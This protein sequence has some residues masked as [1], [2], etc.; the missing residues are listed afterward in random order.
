MV[1]RAR[2]QVKTLCGGVAGDL[3][4]TGSGTEAVLLGMV[5]LARAVSPRGGHLVI[6]AVEHRAGLDAGHQLESLGF[7][8]TWVR[9]DPAGHLDPARVAEALLPDTVLVSIMHAN[10]ETGVIHPVAEIAGIC[11]GRGV[12]MHVD[13]IQSAGKIPVEADSWGVDGLSLAA[14]KLGGPQGV[15]ALWRRRGSPIEPLF[16]GPQEGGLR[17]GTLN[18]AGIVGFGIAAEAAGGE[19]ERYEA[20]MGER[21]RALEAALVAQVPEAKVTGTESPR[22]PNTVHLTFDP[23]VG[24]DLVVALDL[25]GYAVSAGSACR[26]GSEEPSPVLLAMGYSPERARTSVR[27]SFGMETTDEDLGGFVQVLARMVQS[28]LA[29]GTRR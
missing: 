13:A 17:G 28:R 9:P 3:V 4:F 25:E 14:H 21:R 10:N 15:G 19:L 7:P 6:S 1:E 27:V 22:L 2:G 23:A 18:V 26:S 5:G 11:R 12:R 8:V 29:A 16:P 24:P 20:R